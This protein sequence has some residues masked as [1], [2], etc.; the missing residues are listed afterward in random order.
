MS[1]STRESYP[2]EKLFVA[3]PS[4]EHYWGA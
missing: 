4:S 2:M 1:R 3:A